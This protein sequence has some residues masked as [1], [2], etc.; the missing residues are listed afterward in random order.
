MSYSLRLANSGLKA[1]K[2][3]G[4]GSFRATA[5]TP[6]PSQIKGYNKCPVEI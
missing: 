5:I 1:C 6:M 4:I 2:A 3:H